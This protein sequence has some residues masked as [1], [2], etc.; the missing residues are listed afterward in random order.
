MQIFL[1]ATVTMVAFA[2]NSILT[3]LAIDAGFSRAQHRSISGQQMGILMLQ[4]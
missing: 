2:A 3:R 4:A 1:L